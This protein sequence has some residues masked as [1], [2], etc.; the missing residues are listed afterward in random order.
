[1]VAA[2]IVHEDWNDQV[3]H[4]RRLS[5]P[6]RLVAAREVGKFPLARITSAAVCKQTI[7]EPLPAGDMAFISNSDPMYLWALRLLLER[8]SWSWRDREPRKWW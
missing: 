3:L 4:F 6:K 8:V 1:M 7:G 5:R 2:V